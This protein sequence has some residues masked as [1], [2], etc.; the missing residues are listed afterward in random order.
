MSRAPRLSLRCSAGL[1]LA[2]AL[3]AAAAGCLKVPVGDLDTPTD[4]AGTP[5][6]AKAVRFEWPAGSRLA[7]GTVS[8][9][10]G[11]P[12]DENTFADPR[13][14]AP[15]VWADAVNPS[16]PWTLPAH[17]ISIVT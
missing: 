16:A 10:S 1:A 9:L 14:V 13:R 11:R 15:R 6:E 12:G 7:P 17:S 8:V 4:K 2:L 5:A 3:P